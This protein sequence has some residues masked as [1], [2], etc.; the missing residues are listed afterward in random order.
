MAEIQEDAAI[1]ESADH[2]NVP[3]YRR[4]VPLFRR[5]AQHRKVPRYRR[6]PSSIKPLLQGLLRRGHTLGGGEEGKPA[7]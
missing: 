7:L 6:V 3:R 5:V 1:Q 2:I 4:R